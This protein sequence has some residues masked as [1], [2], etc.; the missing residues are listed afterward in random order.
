L[1]V[2]K[3]TTAATALGVALVV[4]V[5]G[6]ALML[7]AG[8]KK[9]LAASGKEDVAIVLRKGSDAELGSSIEDSSIGTILAQPGIKQDGGKPL[10]CA[11]TV[12]V[13]AIEKVGIKG[14][15]NVQVRGVTP[16]SL[17]LRPTI[18]IVEGR[19]ARP[20]S[21]EVIIGKRIAGRFKDV[22]LNHSFDLK[23]NRPVQVVGVFVDNGSSHESEVWADR[24]TLRAAFGREGSVSSVRVR[25]ESASKLDGFRIAVEQDKRLGL[26]VSRETVFYEKQS[27]G[28]AM[29]ISIMGSL[30]AVFF[31]IG[32]MI[33]AMITMYA[34]VANRQREIGTLR[35]LGFSRLAI[36]TSFLM[37][38]TLLAAIG[39]IIGTATS[40]CMGMVSF[41]MINFASWS[42]LVFTFD[43]TPKILITALIFSVG[44][45]LI[46]GF[47]PAVRAARV[48]PIAAMRG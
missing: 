27:E 48:S 7:S 14:L 38:S 19:P 39:G 20:G 25:L 44:M 34:A 47:F 2:R 45:G 24:D 11:E 4:F 13:L 36:L 6:S 40:M 16:E 26:A 18:K 29:F 1:A 8:V 9:T 5:L 32:A 43:P 10:G 22:E 30:I 23:K 3:A 17:T 31:S 37:E 33:G 12:V 35:A 42:E 28:L 15:T 46:G 21:D 41:S